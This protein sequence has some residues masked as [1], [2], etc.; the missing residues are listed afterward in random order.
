M[1]QI[2]RAVQTKLEVGAANDPA[3][4]EADAVADRVLSMSSPQVTA[5]QTAPGAATLRRKPQLNQPN[6]DALNETPAIPEEQQDIELTKGED[7]QTEA[8]DAEELKEIESGEPSGGSGDPT[9]TPL[10]RAVVPVV[11]PEGGA[12][13]T[14][15][16]EAITHPGPGRTLPDAVRAN[17][18]PRFGTD[19]SD[20]RLHDRPTDRDTAAAIGARAFAFGRDIWLGDGERAEDRRLMAH[21]LTHVL[22]QTGHRR[23]QQKHQQKTTVKPTRHGPAVNRFLGDAI[24]EKIAKYARHVPGYT[25][26]GYLIGKDPITLEPVQQNA[27]NL[28]YGLLGLIPF[29]T[30]LADRLKETRALQKAYDW[31]KGQLTKLNLTWDRVKRTISNAKSMFSIWSPV[32]SIKPAFAP[33]LRDIMVFVLKVKEKVQEFIIRGALALAGPWAEKVW[34]VLK[35]AGQAI[36]LILKDPLGFAK[37]LFKAIGQGFGRFFDNFAKH[38]KK[39]ILGFIFGALDGIDIQLPEKLDLKGILSIVFQV[40]RLTWVHIR[41]KLVKRLG[42]NGE[43]KVSLLEKSVDVLKLLLTKGVMGIWKK[44][45]SMIESLTSTI[46]G[47]LTTFLFETVLKGALSWLAGLTNPVGAVIKVILT[48]YNFVVMLIERMQQIIDFVK[49]V[50]SSLFQIAKGNVSAAAAKVEDSLVRTVP[51]IL[52]FLAAIIPVSGITRKIQ[53]IMKKLRKPVDKAI[54]KLLKFLVKKGKKYLSKIIGK[55]NKKRKLPS[56]EFK[57]GATTHRLFGKKMGKVAETFV[58]S[59][60]TLSEKERKRQKTEGTRFKKN[61]EGEEL[62]DVLEFILKF[63]TQTTKADDEADD[64]QLESKK[65]PMTK[66]IKELKDQLGKAKIDLD[67]YGIKL[68]NNRHVDTSKGAGLFRFADPATEFEGQAGL[69][70]DLS[71]AKGEFKGGDV[72]HLE[73]DHNPNRSSLQALQD[74]IKNS[75]TKNTSTAIYFKPVKPGPNAK[76][77][78]AKAV[79]GRASLYSAKHATAD[80]PAIAIHAKYNNKMAAKDGERAAEITKLFDGTD[81]NPIPKVAGLL[82]KQIKLK[83]DQTRSYYGKYEKTSKNLWVN[84]NRGLNNVNHLAHTELKLADMNKPRNFSA[85]SVNLIRQTGIQGFK[86]TA[87]A[88]FIADEGATG[89]YGNLSGI[90]TAKNQLE[91]DHNPMHSEMRSS[92]AWTLGTFLDST[93]LKKILSDPRIAKVTSRNTSRLRSPNA[94]MDIETRITNAIAEAKLSTG[95]AYSKSAGGSTIVGYTVNQD[96]TMKTSPGPLK[97]QVKSHATEN[98]TDALSAEIV[99]KG[100]QKKTRAEITKSSVSAVNK[101]IRK[102]LRKKIAERQ[103]SLFILYGKKELPAVEHANESANPGSGKKGVAAL[104]RIAARVKSSQ[105]T[106]DLGT[107]TDGFFPI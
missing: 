39:G 69:Y 52:A 63:D 99:T 58:A 50:F 61:I 102:K 60:T 90:K 38:L 22:Q 92:T 10:R 14:A 7:V 62:K 20:V 73:L 87:A 2:P 100:I 36:G 75:K 65:K 21:E 19:F 56:V 47:G 29:G 9:A 84:V 51:L 34:G 67:Q 98:F 106:A 82:E 64:I 59:K 11:G 76:G 107:I 44:M 40:L 5:R 70:S 96:P 12:A 97:D 25:L 78:A 85:K 26:V 66:Q 3:E 57:V 45:V 33:L 41:K 81:N 101:G 4:K 17:L 88:N 31:V 53:S 48:I 55:V 24:L 32:K 42:A 37:N 83:T 86:K 104:A 16:E 18:E 28:I 72:S 1:M 6:A 15:V 49:S 8:L 93:A 91:A 54:D 89:A 71:S 30:L 94:K 23:R 74:G 105:T 80:F 43:K 27:E 103:N 35:S 79:F 46:I 77:D 68:E 13:P 95:K